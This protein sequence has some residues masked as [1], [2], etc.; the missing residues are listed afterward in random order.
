MAVKACLNGGRSRDEHP[1]LPQTPGELASDAVAVRAAGAFA[2]HVHPRNARGEQTLDARACD[3]A[4]AALR[5]AAPGLPVG[6]STAA[7]IDP[8]PFARA[9]AI[10]SWRQRPD[11]VSVNLSELGWAGLVRAALHAGIGVE[12]GL[13]TCADAEELARSPF[14][15]QIVR[16]LVEVEGGAPDAQAISRL[17]APE[18]A[19]LWHGYGERTW[20]VL[21]AA[22]AAGLDVRVGLEDVLVLPDGS[23]AP[24]NA[25]LVAAAVALAGGA[26]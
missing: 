21:T 8:D 16:A 15:H 18:V 17:I 25:A 13:S 4:V 11:F 12:A 3:A 7:T 24:S 1:A 14:T 20:E 23:P 9:A 10:G 2:V 19:Q 5:A 22:G 6:L 26:S